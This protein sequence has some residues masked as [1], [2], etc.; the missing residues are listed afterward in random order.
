MP[1][2]QRAVVCQ[3]SFAPAVKVLKMAIM[4]EYFS[5]DRLSNDNFD[6]MQMEILRRKDMTPLEGH[7]PRI[8]RT[9][10]K[11]GAIIVH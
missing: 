4:K 2:K 7:M 3:L 1:K 6:R 9:L 5:S 10:L 8:L 11:A